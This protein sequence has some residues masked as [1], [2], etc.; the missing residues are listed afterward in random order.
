MAGAFGLVAVVTVAFPLLSARKT[1]PTDGPLRKLTLPRPGGNPGDFFVSPDG[2]WLLFGSAWAPRDGKSVSAV[3]LVRRMD[4]TEWRELPG[5]AGGYA[6]FWSPDSRQ[7]GFVQGTSLKKVDLVGSQP[8]TLCSGCITGPGL[9][10]G[11][12]WSQHGLIVFS[13]GV[14]QVLLRIADRGGETRPVTELDS[15]RQETEHFY[16]SFLP[17]G[18]RF[19]FTARS[20]TGNHCIK[21]GSIDSGIPECLVSSYSRSVY[22]SGSLL[23]VR[24][25]SL[26]ALPFDADQGKVTGDPVALEKGVWN[27]F[28]GPAYFSV[29]AEGTL[30]IVPAVP[31]H[32]WWVDR[33]GKRIDELNFPSLGHWIPSRT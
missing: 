22:A 30:V 10:R 5:T 31:S 24:D 1:T 17:D 6:Y 8:Q 25:D 33:T 15:A 28:W 32:Y 2:Q 4:S 14:G 20:H 19:L 12:T 21:L 26:L 9:S 3:A 23:F 16:P 11:G 29:S 7:A 18:R 13:P 27:S